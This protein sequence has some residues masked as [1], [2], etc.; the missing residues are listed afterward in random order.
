M[1]VALFQ[2][3]KLALAVW[4]IAP[5]QWHRNRGDRGVDLVRFP[6][7]VFSRWALAPVAGSQ[8]RG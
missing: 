3:R 4:A 6:K 1:L 7:I 8:N 2:I 5:V